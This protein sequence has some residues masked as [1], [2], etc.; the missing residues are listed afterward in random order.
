MDKKAYYKEYY[1]NNQTYF[2]NRNKIKDN[3]EKKT[4]YKNYYQQNKLKKKLKE[5]EKTILKYIDN[6]IIVSF[7]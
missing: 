7:D 3:D 4:Y 2:T 6:K 5:S 1:K